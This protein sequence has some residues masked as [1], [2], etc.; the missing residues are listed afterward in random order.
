MPCL[1]LCTPQ[2]GAEGT[3]LLRSTYV[4]ALAAF[5][6]VAVM[7]SAE[8]R[9]DALRFLLERVDGVLLTGGGDVDPHFYGRRESEDCRDVCEIRDRLE[10][11]ICRAAVEKKIPLLGICRG[12]QVLNVA[13]GGTLTA[14]IAGHSETV[15]RV[16]T[17][18]TSPLFASLGCEA[19]V[20]SYHHQCIDRIAPSLHLEVA[21]SDGCPEAVM[22][23]QHPF[24]LGVQWHPERMEDAA[25]AR[26]AVFS[27]FLH[28]CE[29]KKESTK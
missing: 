3:S 8:S 13:L 11:A 23:R 28:A 18:K 25:P 17:E 9:E 7:P 14:H 4:T 16:Q 2:A 15:H 20:N 1:I 26:T 6:G 27:A 10:I 24:C 22:L 5:G 19:T 21:A 12:I 29:I